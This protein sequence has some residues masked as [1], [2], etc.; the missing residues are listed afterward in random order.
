MFRLAERDYGLD[1]NCLALLSRESY[2]TLKS[3][4]NGAGKH[5]GTDEPDDG[6]LDALGREGAHFLAEKADAEADGQVTHIERDKLKHRARR[7]ASV[8]RAAAT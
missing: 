2:E 4:R 8:A 6:T 1:L 3:Y 7:I 5:I